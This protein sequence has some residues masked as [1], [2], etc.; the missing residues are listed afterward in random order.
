MVDR[1]DQWRLFVAVATLGSFAAAARAERRSPQA[2]TRAIAALE[3]RIG[4]RLL[5]R[6]T[7][8]VSLTSEGA[9][10]LERSRRAIAELDALEAGDESA[11]VRGTLSMTAPTLFGRLHVLPVVESFLRVHEAV[12]VR[13]L[14]V[15]RVVSLA[16]EGV[17]L[18]IRIGKLPD[19]S[20][21]ATKLGEVR[22][23]L[24]A[25]PAY[26]ERAGLPRSPD[27]LSRHACIAFTGTTPIP[28]RWSFPRPGN[29]D[30][31]VRVRPRLIVDDGQAAIDA[32]IAGL[33]IVRLF[34]YQVDR[35]IG[36]GRL[37]TVLA[38]REPR[39]AP[40]HLVHLPG[41]QARVATAFIDH[42]LEQLRARI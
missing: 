31:S 6:T 42:G 20:L 3:T 21:R 25:S 27:D 12:D 38:K 11:T 17:D 18:A 32:A 4:T 37:R 10:Y 40:V 8:S 15:D 36:E 35:A 13:L 39:P 28:D 5:H 33:G 23:V 41:I 22:S 16:E 24:C 19:S 7:R 26:I 30:V 2:V 34:S 29:R 1:V 14:L 9:R